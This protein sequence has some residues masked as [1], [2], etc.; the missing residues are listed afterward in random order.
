[1]EFLLLRYTLLLSNT[2]C[3]ATILYPIA[4]VLMFVGLTTEDKLEIVYKPLRIYLK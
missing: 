4:T 3:L 1:M 2:C